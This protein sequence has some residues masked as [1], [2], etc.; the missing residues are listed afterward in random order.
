MSPKSSLEALKTFI[1]TVKICKKN[2]AQ[3]TVL[4]WRFIFLLGVYLV[5]GLM[6]MSL[7]LMDN[8]LTHYMFYV[9]FLREMPIT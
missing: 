5:L 2:R 9:L 4:S 8:V 7:K 3:C 1:Y 6:E